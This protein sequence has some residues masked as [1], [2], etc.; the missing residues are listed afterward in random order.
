MKLVLA[1]G[2][3]HQVDKHLLEAGTKPIYV[4]GYRVSAPSATFTSTDAAKKNEADLQ[5]LECLTYGLH[6]AKFADG[7]TENLHRR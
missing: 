5:A 1:V 6:E 3:Q 2:T 7:F 4:G